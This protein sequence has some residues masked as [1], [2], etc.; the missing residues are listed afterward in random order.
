MVM[1]EIVI[2]SDVRL[3]IDLPERIDVLSWRKALSRV[4]LEMI[5]RGM[6]EEGTGAD[7]SEGEDERESDLQEMLD[8]VQPV[9]VES[10]EEG[11][12]SEETETEKVRQELDFTGELKSQSYDEYLDRLKAVAVQRSKWTRSE[13]DMRFEGLRA[14]RSHRWKKKDASPDSKEMQHFDLQGLK[15]SGYEGRRAFYLWRLKARYLDAKTLAEEEMTKLKFMI[16]SH[17][18]DRRRKGTNDVWTLLRSHSDCLQCEKIRQHAIGESSYGGRARK[19]KEE[20]D[21][22]EA[23]QKEPEKASGRRRKRSTTEDQASGKTI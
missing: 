7:R 12:K 13:I 18:P 4:K 11:E 5:W 2:D 21:L 9:P 16:A 17:F 8:K 15:E 1:H 23:R 22:I 19:L 14:P 10:A 20:I 3:R 6:D